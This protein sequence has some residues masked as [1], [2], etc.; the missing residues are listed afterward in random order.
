MN[1]KKKYILYKKKFKNLK[2]AGGST[3]LDNCIFDKGNLEIKCKKDEGYVL[4]KKLDFRYF[5]DSDYNFY[6]YEN[7]EFTPFKFEKDGDYDIFI[8]EKYNLHP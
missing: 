8:S 7:N 4:T 2:K 3:E 6:L 1:Y 5:K